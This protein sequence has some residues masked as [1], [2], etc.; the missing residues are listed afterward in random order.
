M[1][2]G[3]GPIGAATNGRDYRRPK[4]SRLALGVARQSRLRIGALPGGDLG[5]SW[6]CKLAALL[7]AFSCA[8]HF[9]DDNNNNNR[10]SNSGLYG[11]LSHHCADR[12]PEPESRDATALR[13]PLS[14]SK[15]DD[16][17]DNDLCD[18]HRL[19]RPL[20]SSPGMPWPCFR[21]K[22]AASQV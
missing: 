13:V 18:S 19:G 22:F 11:P 6:R 20:A 9:D 5:A 2:Q 8:R 21:L 17:E 1:E 7:A 10:E 16:A 12:A 15:T 4:V 3:G 14:A